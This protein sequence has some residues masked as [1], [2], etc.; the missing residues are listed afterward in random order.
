MFYSSHVLFFK[1]LHLVILQKKFLYN[2]TLS[3]IYL[4]SPILYFHTCNS[5]TSFFTT[6]FIRHT[7]NF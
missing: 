2:F 1:F 5:F 6:I 7:G 3:Q 4:F